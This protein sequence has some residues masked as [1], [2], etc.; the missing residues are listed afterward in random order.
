M[1]LAIDLG[2]TYQKAAVFSEDSLIY[3]E[4]T[5]NLSD[6]IE[7][8]FS[9]YPIDGAIISSVITNYDKLSD[10]I[11]TKCPLLFFDELTPI[12][13]TNAY[14][15]PETLGKDRLA[16]V[17]AANHMFPGENILVIDAGSCIKYDFIDTSAVYH[18]GAISPGLTM[19]FKALHTFTGKLPLIELTEFCQLTGFNTQQS[20]LSGVINGTVAEI[21]G[22]ISQYN[23]SYPELKVV[24]SGGDSEYLVNKLK[25]KI[26]AVQNIVLYGLKIILDHN[27]N[28]KN[29]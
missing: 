12:P 28:N 10:F 9:S 5:E 21:N 2:N 17:V 6:G 18:G 25:S 1:K 13:I 19:R 16:S 7:K 20:I 23:S 24:L 26:F 27:D 8:I 29:V 11:T 15:T 4:K 3:V 22:I 14:A